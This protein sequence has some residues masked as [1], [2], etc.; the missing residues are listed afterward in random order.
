M[1]SE[2]D[3]K[4]KLTTAI[5]A[6][7]GWYCMPHGAGY[8]RAGIPDIVACLPG[9]QFAAYEC[10][11]GSNKLSAHQVRELT[12]IGGSGGVAM[13]V[14]ETNVDAVVAGLMRS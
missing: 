5:T 2:R 14:D 7:G 4:R 1:K 9:G 8:G 12:A 10:K 3:V 6:V 11:F 13:Q